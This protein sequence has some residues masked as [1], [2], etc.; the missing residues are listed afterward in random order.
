MSYGFVYIWFDKEKKRFYIGSHWGSETDGY[1]CSSEA[2]RSAYRR[3]PTDFKRRI[4]KRVYTTRKEL[5][6]EEYN[7]LKL[8]HDSDLGRK[9][10][11]LSNKH[12]GHWTAEDNVLTIGEKISLAKK[13]KTL[14]EETKRK[15]SEARKGKPKSNGMTGKKLSE[16]HKRAISEASKGRRFSVESRKKMSLSKLGNSNRSRF[17]I[18]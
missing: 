11:N 5:L 15:M 9:Y 16:E 7:W 14:S 8:I 17:K 6:E 12:F 10:Y 2:M 13:G 3:R 1:V 4:L 18:D